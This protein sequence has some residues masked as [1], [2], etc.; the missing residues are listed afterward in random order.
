MDGH[1]AEGWTE[2][3]GGKKMT[4][5]V[6]QH[7]KK[8]GLNDPVVAWFDV[9]NSMDMGRKVSLEWSKQKVKPHPDIELFIFKIVD[10]E[11]L[12][13]PVSTKSCRY[14]GK[15]HG[16][17][18]V[19]D[20]RVTPTVLTMPHGYRADPRLFGFIDSTDPESPFKP[21]PEAHDIEFEVFKLTGNVMGMKLRYQMNFQVKPTDVYYPNLWQPAAN[22]S[23]I[24]SDASDGGIYIPLS[25]ADV[26]FRLSDTVF[27]DI[28]AVIAEL[29]GTVV[30][31]QFA[32]P[33]ISILIMSYAGV[34]LYI[35]GRIERGRRRVVDEYKAASDD[36]A[37]IINS[38]GNM[39]MYA[40]GNV[41]VGGPATAAD[42][43]RASSIRA[44]FWDTSGGEH[45]ESFH[46]RVDDDD[47]GG[48][49]GCGG[50]GSARSIGSGVT[51]TSVASAVVVNVAPAAT[52]PK[53]LS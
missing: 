24:S 17:W 32:L 48:C 25:W 36:R 50:G 15:Y 5:A 21:D 38:G 19:S 20:H 51:T 14:S 27:E 13:C 52:T 1:Y 28:A 41:V 10:D 33:A 9:G 30:I 16:V 3:V 42:T 11:L 39:T 35:R 4:N 40:P 26:S 31:F 6:Y 45:Y 46:H 18:N 8:Y 22:S 49:G 7:V 47:C 2:Q 37:S 34:V 29:T 12:P 44:T 43:S 23:L 53:Y